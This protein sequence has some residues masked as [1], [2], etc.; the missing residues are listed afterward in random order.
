[1]SSLAFLQLQSDFPQGGA[2]LL[3]EL[4]ETGGGG[5]GSEVRRL[6]GRWGEEDE[7]T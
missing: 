1:M 5:T 6:T 3:A 4:Q 7:E 2:S